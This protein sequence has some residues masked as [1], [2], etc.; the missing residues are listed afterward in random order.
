[1]QCPSIHPPPT[2]TLGALGTPSVSPSISHP[3]PDTEGPA[4]PGC[5]CHARQ[6]PAP[7]AAL[8]TRRPAT[9]P[10]P[11]AGH[12]LS[13]PATRPQAQTPIP[14]QDARLAPG[15]ENMDP[16]QQQ[17]LWGGSNPSPADRP[18]RLRPPHCRR[19]RC[20]LV[21]TCGP[22]NIS[23]SLGPRLNSVTIEGVKQCMRFRR[24]PGQSPSPTRTPPAT[25]TPASLR[26]PTH[27]R[28]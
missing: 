2:H 24:S 16:R 10:A 19:S 13:G 14:R 4:R 12:A 3:L 5:S 22:R 18:P 9:T 23:P 27:W 15:P 21:I 1:M 7:L 11:R 6:A 20:R 28:P 8:A 17:V 26:H 25:T